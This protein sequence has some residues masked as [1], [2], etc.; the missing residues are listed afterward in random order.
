MNFTGITCTSVSFL[1]VRKLVE[2]IIKTVLLEL[3]SGLLWIV[4]GSALKA[5]SQ[6][7]TYTQQNITANLFAKH[8][9]EVERITQ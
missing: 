6:G 5:V 4:C 3:R 7:S 2:W 9:F 8:A 1:S